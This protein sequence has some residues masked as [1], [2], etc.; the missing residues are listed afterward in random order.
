MVSEFTGLPSCLPARYSFEARVQP[1]GR[2]VQHLGMARLP[3]K[4]LTAVDAARHDP[5]NT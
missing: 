3:L 5:E 1:R 4:A 2:Y